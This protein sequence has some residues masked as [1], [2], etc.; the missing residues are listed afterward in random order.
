MSEIKQKEGQKKSLNKIVSDLTRPI[1]NHYGFTPWILFLLTVMGIGLFA[2][3]LQ[4]RDGL[5]VTAMR[6]YVSW[7]L[8][9]SSFIF[10]IATALVGMLISAVLGLIGVKWITP[11]SR[12]AEMIALG[13]AMWAGLII[14]FDMGRPDRVLNIFLHGRLQSPIVWDI[15]VVTTYVAISILLYLLPLIPDIP[16]LKKTMNDQPKWKQKIYKVLS[17]GFKGKPEQYKLIKRL[18]RIMAILIIPVA[19]AIHT[20]TSW[21]FAATLRVGWDSTIFGPYY[22][23]GAFVAGGAAVIIAMFVFSRNFRLKEYITNLHFDKMGKL[24]VMLMLVYLYFNINEYLVPAYKMKLEDEP[25]LM[26]LFT[27]KFALMFWTVQLGGLI[28]P[29]ILL[30]FKKMRKPVPSLII[31]IVVVIGAFFKRYLITIP[32]LLHPHLPIQNVPEEFSTYWPTAFEWT[33]TMMA[34]AGA[35]LI[36][37]ILAKLFPVMPIWETAHEEGITNDEMNKFAEGKNI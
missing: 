14:I 34:V 22:V 6:D 27:G 24:L 1:K 30:L 16:F 3:I 26:G 7:G 28:I 18:I 2:Y 29:T 25:H 4:L 21:L 32:T 10:F 35:V 36:I 8:Y 13:F 5:G 23:S 19:L 17:F 33:I 20:V 12:I 37:T 9:I 31:G 11:I 15:T